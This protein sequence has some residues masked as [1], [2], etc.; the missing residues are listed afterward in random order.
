MIID[1]IVLKN[2]QMVI[3]INHKIN[4]MNNVQKIIILTKMNMNVQMIA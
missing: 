1:N 4:A 3:N 2:V